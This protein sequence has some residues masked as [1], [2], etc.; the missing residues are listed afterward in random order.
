[1]PK[2]I[3]TFFLSSLGKKVIMGA[4]GLLLTFFLI[5]HLGGNLT[6]FVDPA[7]GEKF[8]AYAQGLHDLGPL[9]WLAE[10]GLVVLFGVHIWMALRLTRENRAARPQGYVNPSTFGRAT[11]ASRT[12]PITGALV[13]GFLIMHLAHFR[14]SE[15]FFAP[16]AP[17]LHQRV[18]NVMTNPIWAGAYVIF[19]AVLGLHL[20][21]GFRSAFQSLGANHPRLNSLFGR[22]GTFLAVV[23]G[24]GFAS[25]PIVAVFVWKGLATT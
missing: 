25:F 21:H 14:F 9:L 5:A 2:D 12:M 17:D 1:M 15:G 7:E 10:I 19:A 13:L 11:A 4:T 22:V 20:A 8:I 18:I 16:S 3:G 23:L 24:L 6:L